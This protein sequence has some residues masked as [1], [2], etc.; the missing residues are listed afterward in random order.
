MLGCDIT[1]IAL[2][3][4]EA[5]SKKTLPPLVGLGYNPDTREPPLASFKQKLEGLRLTWERAADLSA[6]LASLPQAKRSSGSV[7]RSQ[8]RR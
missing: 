6:P 3:P 2:S 4:R 8:P 1:A 7:K 5:T